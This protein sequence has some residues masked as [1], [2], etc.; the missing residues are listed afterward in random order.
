[1]PQFK[2]RQVSGGP[3]T[4]DGTKY[5]WFIYHKDR[6]ENS[7][8]LYPDGSTRI[9]CTDGNNH[10]WYKTKDEAIKTLL[11]Y[12]RSQWR[13]SKET[14]TSEKNLFDKYFVTWS[15]TQKLWY[16][17]VVI[18]PIDSNGNAGRF[19]VG[20]KTLRAAKKRCERHL[21][22]IMETKDDDS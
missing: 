12:Y 4:I 14:I 17:Y 3:V 10:G 6:L 16:S 11:K 7:R 8:Y 19:V 22:K 1:M 13:D 20:V 5:S 21:L 9:F 18:E 15:S 2:V